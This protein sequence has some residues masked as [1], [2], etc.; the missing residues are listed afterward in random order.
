MFKVLVVSSQAEP[1]DWGGP[2]YLPAHVQTW[3]MP[4]VATNLFSPLKSCLPS[5]EFGSFTLICDICKNKYDI[6]LYPF[7]PIFT[8]EVVVCYDLLQLNWKWNL[9]DF[10]AIFISTGGMSI[11]PLGRTSQAVFPPK[12][13]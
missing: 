8:V 12:S 7:F 13:G 9:A 5:L 1:S 4:L 10:L 11:I 3:Q 6:L 2:Y